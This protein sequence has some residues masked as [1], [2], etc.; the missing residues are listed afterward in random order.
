MRAS[1]PHSQSGI[2]T[3]LPSLGIAR[4][5]WPSGQGRA[6]A[7]KKSGPSMTRLSPGDAAAPGTARAGAFGPHCPGGGEPQPRP[8]PQPQPQ[9]R[10]RPRRRAFRLELR[11]ET[12]W[13]ADLELRSRRRARVHALVRLTFCRRKLKGPGALRTYFYCLPASLLTHHYS[14]LTY[15]AVAYYAWHP[16]S[17]PLAAGRSHPHSVGLGVALSLSMAA[18]SD[19]RV[20]QHAGTPKF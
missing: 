18:L 19:R 15:C 17:L 1:T 3:S 6:E 16:C 20:I 14:L 4:R 12:K 7:L 2:G 9:P 10:P 8:Q 11:A 13:G 5:R